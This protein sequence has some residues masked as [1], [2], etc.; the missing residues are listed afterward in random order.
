MGK[1]DREAIETVLRHCERDISYDA[2]GTFGLNPGEDDEIDVKEVKKAKRG[3]E[4]IR[5][6]LSAYLD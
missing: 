3:I 2:G 6:I 4:A 1:R 5:W